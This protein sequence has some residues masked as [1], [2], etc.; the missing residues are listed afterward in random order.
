MTIVKYLCLT[1]IGVAENVLPI[2]LI[3]LERILFR[4]P[5][6]AVDQIMVVITIIGVAMIVKGYQQEEVP[7]LAKSGVFVI[8]IL[9]FYAHM[10]LIKMRGLDEFTVSLY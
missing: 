4:Y 7:Q 1:Y 3:I 8:P 5:I 9:L 10:T 2:L 6:A